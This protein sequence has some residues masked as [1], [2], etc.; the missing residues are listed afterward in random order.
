MAT[1]R[2]PRLIGN[3]TAPI[4]K[5]PVIAQDPLAATTVINAVPGQQVATQPQAVRTITDPMAGIPAPQTV[6]N[7]IQPQQIQNKIPPITDPM[8]VNPVTTNES[9]VQNNIAPPVS[10]NGSQAGGTTQPQPSLFGN[11]AGGIGDAYTGTLRDALTGKIFD[12]MAAGTKEAMARAEANKRAAVAGQ[13]AGAGFSGTGIG[14][15]I[16]GG[17]ENN[18]TRQRYDTMIGIEQARNEGRVNALGEARAYGTAEEGIRQYEKD[19][20]E[21]ARRFDT[22]QSNWERG[23]DEDKRR[24]DQN[25]AEDKERYG[26]TQEWKAYEEAMRNGSDADVI[27]AY[28]AATGKDLDPAAVSQY[29]GYYRRGQEQGLEAGR[30]AIDTARQTLDTMKKTEAGNGLANYLATHLDSDMND[31]A[32]GPMMQ[33]YWESLGNTGPV[34]QDWADQQIRAARDVRINT[35]IG[36]MNYQIDQLVASG[37]MKPED[38]ALLKDFNSGGWTQFLVRDPATGKPKFDANAYLA[39]LSGETEDGTIEGQGGVKIKIPTDASGNPTKNNGDYFFGEDGNL[40][41]VEDGVPTSASVGDIVS[42]KDWNRLKTLISEN[43]NN[44]KIV[45][46]IPEASYSM[47]S[48][49]GTDKVRTSMREGDVTKITL[50]GKTIPVKVKRIGKIDKGTFDWA[51][52]EFEGPNGE[53]YFDATNRKGSIGIQAAANSKF[54]KDHSKQFVGGNKNIE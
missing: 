21:G 4:I 9:L 5:K 34:P 36:A 16:A 22:G 44:E 31:P 40:Y 24:Y 26:D 12:P 35:E 23:F 13:I 45:N 1:R 29:R 10:T 49:D 7:N 50:N 11:T 27:S 25:F 53:T 6:N 3:W 37:Q 54:Y 43:P 18:L 8:A 17:V 33:K 15:Q 47:N 19:F 14:Q 41:T 20:G 30:V 52:I 2:D 51:F 32:L 46:D 48:R 39:S 38:A 28:K 42:N